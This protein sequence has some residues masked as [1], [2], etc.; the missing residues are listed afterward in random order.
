MSAST[1]D[2]ADNNSTYTVQAQNSATCALSF[3]ED[4]IGVVGGTVTPD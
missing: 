1:N 2:Q 4:R 3:L